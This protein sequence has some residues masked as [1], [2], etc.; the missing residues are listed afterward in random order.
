MK[1]LEKVFWEYGAYS[2][3]ES[4]AVK[5]S[6]HCDS[7]RQSLY[8][9]AMEK[10]RLGHNIWEISSGVLFTLGAAGVASILV[11]AGALEDD[12][13]AA[14]ADG[15]SSKS[16]WCGGCA[17]GGT[18]G[19]A[20]G[21]SSTGGIGGGSKTS[22]DATSTAAPPVSSSCDASPRLVLRLFDFLR[23]PSS[24]ADAMVL[25]LAF[26]F[27]PLPLP[28]PFPLAAAFSAFFLFFSSEWVTD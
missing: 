14:D 23:L 11:A 21:G 26:P 5:W 2:L 27:L 12:D 4:L 1:A 17:G 28:L 13:A 19:I 8:L 22:D 9:T 16:W 7:S 20:D 18:G 10:S 15:S 25:D 24:S 3:A 6:L